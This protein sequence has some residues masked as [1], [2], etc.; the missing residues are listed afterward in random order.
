MGKTEF[1]SK[2]AENFDQVNDVTS[3]VGGVTSNKD[4]VN[5]GGQV[6]RNMIA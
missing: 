6:L 1:L 5:P 3:V 2:Y 4:N